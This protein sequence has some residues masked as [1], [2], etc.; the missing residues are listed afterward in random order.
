MRDLD[1]TDM[2]ILQLLLSNAR[3]PY[4]EIAETV[5][6]SAPAVSD[7]VAR[8]E[9]A[10]VINRFT[11]DVDRSQ[12]RSGIPVLVTI[13]PGTD[14]PAALRTS[15]LETDAVEHVFTTAEADLV[16]FARVP[17]NDIAGWLA[18]AVD[19]DNV[20]DFE[21]ELLATAAWSPDLGGTEFALSCAQCGNTV[22][23]E[24]TAA[25]IDDSLYQFCCPSCEARF[26]EKYAE[27]QEGAD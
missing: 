12:L 7:R 19:M 27:L 18:D 11:L 6:L 15:L 22:D 23:S 26:E 9:E 14:D 16:V 21:V 4:S 25:R 13:E 10:G 20:A 3:R 1:E 24:G 2:E 17:D 5:G 8:L